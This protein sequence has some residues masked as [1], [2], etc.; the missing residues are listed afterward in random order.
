MYTD[1]PHL[2]HVPGNL[3]FLN[4]RSIICIYLFLYTRICIVRCQH[5]PQAFAKVFQ[6]FLD[7][8]RL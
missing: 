3:K 5:V 6:I 4:C 1:R 8:Y 7:L 2:T